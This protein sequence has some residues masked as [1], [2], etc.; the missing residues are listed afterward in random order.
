M[1]QKGMSMLLFKKEEMKETF[2]L[3]YYLSCINNIIKLVDLNIDEVDYSFVS[4]V[5][6]YKNCQPYTVTNQDKQKVLRI[7]KFAGR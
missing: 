6:D 2:V 4:L 1:K 3:L 5:N 7:A